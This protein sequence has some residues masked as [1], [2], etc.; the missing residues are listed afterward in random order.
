MFDIID[1]IS[2]RGLAD[3]HVLVS[4]DV[5]NMIPNIDN[6]LCLKSVKNALLDNN[7]DLDS[8]QCIVHALEICFTCKNSTFN[9]Q[10][11]LHDD[12][13]TQGPLMSC[14]YADIAIT[15]YDSLARVWK[16]F[17]EDTLYHG[18]MALLLSPYFRGNFTMEIA[19]ILL[20]HYN[21]QKR[22]E[23]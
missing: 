8:T 3:K 14:S 20:T 21:I 2:G 19:T 4:F 23:Y 16:I 13:M 15:K 11:F 10:N 6:N 22:K 12:G 7:F 17:T 18:N 1:S 9:H 5:V